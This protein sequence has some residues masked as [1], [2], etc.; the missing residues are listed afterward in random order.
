M[1]VILILTSIF[2]S[3]CTNFWR[4][5]FLSL[6]S[7]EKKL[8][9]LLQNLLTESKYSHYPLLL[10]VTCSL[11][12]TIN[13]LKHFDASFKESNTLITSQMVMIFSLGSGSGFLASARA[14]AS[15]FWKTVEHEL[16]TMGIQIL[17]G[18]FSII[19]TNMCTW[20]KVMVLV[21]EDM[22]AEW[23]KTRWW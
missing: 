21:V 23:C 19:H 2:Q 9:L 22:S 3:P 18:I 15:K 13:V 20:F 8:L 4:W 17:E 16:L 7:A 10:L 12:F 14:S 1:R 5:K 11:L 6:K